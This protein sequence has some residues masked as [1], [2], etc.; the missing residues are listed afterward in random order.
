MGGKPKEEGIYVYMCLFHF[1]VQ[2]KLTYCKAT[3]LQEKKTTTFFLI[4]ASRIYSYI[5]APGNPS[6]LYPH[7]CLT[8]NLP[9][10][11]DSRSLWSSVRLVLWRL[12]FFI[13]DTAGSWVL[14]WR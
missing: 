10:L 7:H 4:Y 6:R 11:L 3:I 14:S 2:Q 1:A 5:C 9:L 13:G 8:S 12:T